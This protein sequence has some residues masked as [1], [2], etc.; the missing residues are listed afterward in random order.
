M[1]RFSVVVALDDGAEVV[2]D[3]DLVEVVE[4]LPVARVD[5]IGILAEGS[6]HL[7]RRGSKGR[8]EVR[9]HDALEGPPA[10]VVDPRQS[11]RGRP[12]V[13]E[14]RENRRP[15]DFV[16]DR[17]VARPPPLVLPQR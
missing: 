1:V 16:R 15:H 6:P 13:R 9:R 11:F 4:L 7:R 10:D 3:D 14:R 8:R 2:V 5:F 17:I 12:D